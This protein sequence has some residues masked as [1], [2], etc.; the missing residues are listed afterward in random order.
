MTSRIDEMVAAA[1]ARFV[2]ITPVD[3]AGEVAA[4]AVLVDVRL[5][6][7]RAADGVIPGA[8]HLPLNSL[9]WRL[10]PT[11]TYRVPEARDGVRVILFCNE[12]YCS[13]LAALR[14]RDLGVDATDIDGGFQAWRGAG[15]PVVAQDAAR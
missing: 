7:Q 6:E 10:D 14:L 5:T 11:S 8:L 15:L 2:R 4:G 12:G 3:A 13:S 9:E 1:R